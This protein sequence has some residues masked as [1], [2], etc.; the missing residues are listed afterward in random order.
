MTWKRWR[1][2]PGGC[3]GASRTAAGVQR[4]ADGCFEGDKAAILAYGSRS[5]EQ[6]VTEWPFAG[7]GPD[8]QARGLFLVHERGGFTGYLFPYLG[9]STLNVHCPGVY[10]PV[11]VAHEM[12]HQ[13]GWRPSRKRTFL[14]IA[15]CL[16]LPDPVYQYPGGCLATAPVQCAFIPPT[17]RPGRRYG[18]NWTRAARRISGRIMPIGIPSARRSPPW[19]KAATRIFCRAMARPLGLASFTGRLRGPFWWRGTE[20]RRRPG[21]RPVTELFQG[22]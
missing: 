12:A 14:G 16:T 9:E 6:L 2:P 15:A 1:Q 4:G 19:C 18:M 3:Q 13:R 11:T 20:R 7:A 10:L 17:K 5:Y 21:S 22:L 8:P